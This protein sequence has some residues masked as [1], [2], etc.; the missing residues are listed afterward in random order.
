MKLKPLLTFVATLA[1]GAN[2]ATAEE[3]TPLS[4]EMSAMNKS[5][6][7]LKRQVADPAKK[8]D[9]VAL[10]DEMKKRVEAA[11]KFEPAKT[12]D[13]PAADKSKYLE[14]YKKQLGDLGKLI[15]EL[16]AAVDKGDAP[17]AQAIFDKLADSKEKGHQ[18]FAPE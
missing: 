1:V 4:K 7:T 2:F 18:K 6:R 8:A 9:N 13:Q 3:D 11:T 15:D 12:K 16:K 10:V 17:G 14:E 5:L